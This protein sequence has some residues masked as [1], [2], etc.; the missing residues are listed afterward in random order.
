ML[1]QFN[2]IYIQSHAGRL[3]TFAADPNFG[4]RLT[5]PALP[6]IH[7]ERNPHDTESVLISLNRKVITKRDISNVH[8]VNPDAFVIWIEYSPEF[9]LD[10]YTPRNKACS[11]EIS[12]DA[13]VCTSGRHPLLV[14]REENDQT[15]YEKVIIHEA[16]SPESLRIK[17]NYAKGS[18][19]ATGRFHAQYQG[20]LYQTAF[21]FRATRGNAGALGDDAWVEIDL[22]ELI[23]VQAGGLR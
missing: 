15:G 8:E 14:S 4:E 3:V 9:D 12:K 6:G 18:G 2:A 13:P 17:I 23:R 7:A 21:S 10:L 22:G 19:R 5:T 11:I 20:R 16:A 1:E